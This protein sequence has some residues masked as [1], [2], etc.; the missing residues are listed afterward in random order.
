[1]TK[2]YSILWMVP[3][4]VY[5]F[6]TWC[7]LDH[8]QYLHWM[9]NVMAICL[10][11]FVWTC[12]IFFLWTFRSRITGS[13]NKCMFNFLRICSTVSKHSLPSC[14]VYSLI[15]KNVAITIMVD[16]TCMWAEGGRCG[17]YWW[18]RWFLCLAFDVLNSYTST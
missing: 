15:G 11:V 6:T 3:H 14:W 16:G 9:N 5:P 1:M 18:C 2:W 17:S 4:S 7:T 8:F 10:H 13:C 12:F